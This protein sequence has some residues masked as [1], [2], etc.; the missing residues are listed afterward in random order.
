VDGSGNT[1]SGRSVSRGNDFL[2]VQE[3]DTEETDWVEGNKDEREDDGNVGRNK[4]IVCD[5]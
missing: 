5:L 2:T 1:R 4:V 3:V